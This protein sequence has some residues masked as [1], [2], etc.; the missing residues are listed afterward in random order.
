VRYAGVLDSGLGQGDGVVLDAGEH[1]LRFAG[2]SVSVAG[3]PIVRRL[4][5]LLAKN[6]NEEVS[7]EAIALGVWE[8]EYD[9]RRHDN[10]IRVTVR[11][12]REL[13]EGTPLRISTEE[14][15]YRLVAPS[16]F[17]FKARD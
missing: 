7:K 13:F 8:R 15:G 11:R 6:A 2:K 16:G 5:Y 9:P 10:P 1:V 12:A 3:R 14:R 17:V 4:L